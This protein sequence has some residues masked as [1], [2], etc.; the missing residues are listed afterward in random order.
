MD[1]NFI[2]ILIWL[3]SYEI[4]HD[5]RE[6]EQYFK[7]MYDLL[8][9]SFIKCDHKKCDRKKLIFDDYKV[10]AHKIR[11]FYKSH[12]NYS[13]SLISTKELIK[14]LQNDKYRSEFKQVGIIG[15]GAYGNVFKVKNLLDNDHYAIKKIPLKGNVYNRLIYK[16]INNLIK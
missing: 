7:N 8:N 4:S 12:I 15:N 1:V 11:N 2:E 14:R 9:E 3:I 16:I 10:I 6:Q 13:L 5:E